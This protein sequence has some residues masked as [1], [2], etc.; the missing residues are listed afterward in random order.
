[1]AKKGSGLTI[2][3]RPNGSWRAQ[4]RKA[5]FPY[6]SKDFLSH[7]E[8]DEWGLGRLAEIQATGRLVNRKPSERTTLGE[9]IEAYILEKTSERRS[10]S[11]RV[12]EETR[13]RRFLR[14]EKKLCDYALAYVTPEMFEDWR[15]RRLNETVSRGSPPKPEVIPP[16]RLKADGTPRKNAAKAK[17]PPRP[18]KTIS[19]STVKREMTCL[20]LVFDYAIK[21]YKLTGNPLAPELVDR[22]VVQDERNVRLTIE[23]WHLLLEACRAARNRWLAPFVELALEIGARRGSLTKVLWSDVDLDHG[24]MTL[25]DVKN[26]RKPNE[27][28]TVEVGLSPRAIEVL[29]GMP[30][31]IDGKVFPLSTN[32]LSQA[33]KRA[34]ARA[35]LSFFRLHDTRHELASR[36]V[37][38]GWQVVDVMAQGD[39]RDPKSLKRYYGARGK[40]LAG[41]L[42]LLPRK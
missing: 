29:R 7:E 31:S 34:R 25:R 33:F 12:P 23:Q 21:E 36:L 13:L 35:N 42:A 20:K 1:M 37:E 11:S 32:A 30:R 17:A 6:E 40:H 4:I 27:I 28:R 24:A 41:K 16:G 2:V 8:A 10:E 19:A 3:Q 18:L 38:A 14:V 22:P 15:K 5:G 39:W 26:S 9:A